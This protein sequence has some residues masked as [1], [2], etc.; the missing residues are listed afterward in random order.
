MKKLKCAV[1]GTGYLGKFHAEKYVNH[2]DCELVAVVDVD[3]KIAATIAEK[4]HCKAYT[5]YAALLSNV[6]AVSIVVPTSLHH[7]VAKDFLTAG[8]H[9]LVEKPMTVTVEEADELIVIAKEKN[10]V[11]QVGHLE[12]FNPAILGLDDESKPLFIESH[13]LSP[14]NPRANDV[15]VVLDLMIHD[16]DIILALVDSEVDRIEAS[17]TPVLTKG[18]DI[19]N[20]RLTFKNGCVANVTASRIS[21]K[22]E[23]KMRMFRPCSYISVDF[24]N[25]ILTK[26]R[27]SDKEMYPGIPEIETEEFVF[28]ESDALQTEINHFINCIQTN[29][30]PLVSGEAGKHALAT[31]IKITTLLSQSPLNL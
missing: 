1:I 2:S 11:L 27:T 23:R 15:S 12:R 7:Q 17:G 14:F 4:Y 19:A 18:T 24:Q 25:K 31:A 9:V 10:R 21:L 13:R 3:L 16:I 5:D 28:K 6:D 22:M 29:T 30:T 20:A 26:H 8:A